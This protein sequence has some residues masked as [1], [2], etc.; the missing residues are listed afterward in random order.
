METTSPKVPA[1]TPA[2]QPLPP[3]DDA[4]DRKTIARLRREKDELT[5][6]LHIYEDYIRWLT[7][8]NARLAVEVNRVQGITRLSDH[9]RNRPD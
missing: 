6:H 4:S 1:L 3:R 2:R 5:R 8:E 7:M 9:H